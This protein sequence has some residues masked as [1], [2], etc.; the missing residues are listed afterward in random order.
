MEDKRFVKLIIGVILSLLGLIAVFSFIAANIPP[1]MHKIVV[2]G[3]LQEAEVSNQSLQISFTQPMKPDPIE[4]SVTPNVAYT[5]LW[6]NNTLF[7]HFSDPLLYGTEYRV[8]IIS[9]L[10]NIYGKKL[11]KEISLNFTT[12]QAKII[13]QQYPDKILSSNVSGEDIKILYESHEIADFIKFGNTVAVLKFPK[14]ESTEII[15][16]DT[17][18][19]ETES[20]SIGYAVYA[21]QYSQA[22]RKLMLLAQD[23][24]EPNDP[25]GTGAHLRQL[26][27]YDTETHAVEPFASG[28]TLFEV[29]NFLLSQNG[30]IVLYRD[31]SDSIYYL[32]D[33]LKPNEKPVLIG[34][35]IA[36]NEFDQS[37]KTMLFTKED[38]QSPLGYLSIEMYS[39][40][41]QKKSLSG[42]WI[43][44][45]EPVF[46]PG[47]D[48]IV[49][50][51]KYNAPLSL[52]DLFRV[53]II[54]SETGEVVF[55]L[56][57]EG[58]SYETPRVSRNGQFAIVEKFSESQ[59]A[60]TGSER[61]V[62]YRQK[63]TSAELYMIR[64]DNN[65]V[66][67]LPVNGIN[68]I[69]EE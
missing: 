56:F 41:G 8:A 62:G 50:S 20:H 13:F 9:Q 3:S 53:K 28:E 6:Q 63:G 10:E 36:A 69:F 7:I 59:L 48:A 26:Y 55:D 2:N 37:G 49:Y 25:I 21:M 64:L 16:I 22:V 29:D 38:D 61:I 66:V 60:G 11:D 23:I 54:N 27:F 4:L 68:V 30:R 39:V 43:H 15:L 5:T 35:Y 17:E 33:V 52:L 46:I 44:A 18:S 57:E 45:I 14:G 51:E 67:R 19:G 47:T 58:Y 65:E 32:S 42:Q 12:K 40:G 1:H 31:I 24:R 34:N